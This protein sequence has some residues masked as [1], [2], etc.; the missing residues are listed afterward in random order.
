M[1]KR[2]SLARVAAQIE[3]LQ[4]QADLLRAKHKKPVIGAIIEAMTHYGISHEELRANA[5]QKLEKPRRKSGPNAKL[6]RRNGATRKVRRVAPK[7]RNPKTGETWSG[8]GSPA[9][10]LAEAE[11]QGKSRERFLIR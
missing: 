3:L 5:P 9:R 2:L 4:R 8:R 10:W 1:P 11:R 7:Y 6:D